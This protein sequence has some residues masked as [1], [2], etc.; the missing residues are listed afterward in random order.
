MA[1]CEGWSCVLPLVISDCLVYLVHDTNDLLYIH[2][3]W[4]RGIPV[5]SLWTFL[6]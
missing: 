1:C 3:T 5:T 2:L 4:G 6:A